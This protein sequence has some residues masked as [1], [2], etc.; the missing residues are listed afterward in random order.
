VGHEEPVLAGIAGEEGVL[1]GHRPDL[2]E[3]PLRHDRHLVGG[4]ARVLEEA[5]LGPGRRQRLFAGAYHLR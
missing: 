3:E 2:G 5:V 4:I 1:V